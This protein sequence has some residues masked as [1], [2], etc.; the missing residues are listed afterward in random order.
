[1]HQHCQADIGIAVA[2][3]TDVSKESADLGYLI[4]V[5]T[6]SSQQLR[7]EEGFLTTSEK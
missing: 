5:L 4:R 3:A 7:K 1:M 6:Q 2:E